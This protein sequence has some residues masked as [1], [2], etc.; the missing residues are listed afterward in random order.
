MERLFGS[1]AQNIQ[2]AIGPCIGSCCYEVDQPVKD[3]FDKNSTSWES[4]AESSAPGKWRLDMALANR[5]QL[6]EAGVPIAAIQSAGMC[7]CCQRELFF[8]H[9][10]DNGETGRQMG[11]I[12][13]TDKS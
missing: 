9:R 3:G 4:V 5:M 2:A 8:S 10:R 13:L 12:M 1:C 11:F 7:V 6:E